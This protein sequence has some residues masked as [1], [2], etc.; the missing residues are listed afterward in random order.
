M[1]RGGAFTAVWKTRESKFA[2]RPTTAGNDPPEEK[3]ASV[4]HGGGK[5]GEAGVR[6]RRDCL[7]GIICIFAGS[8]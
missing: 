6:F 5:Q 4:V 2:P 3:E 8:R 1:C 7:R